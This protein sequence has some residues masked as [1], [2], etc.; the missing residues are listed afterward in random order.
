MRNVFNVKLKD[1]L[2]SNQS[3]HPT[4]SQKF[5][6]KL[7]VC[8]RASIS[9]KLTREH[10]ELLEIKIRMWLYGLPQRV[11]IKPFTDSRPYV[12]V[13]HTYSMYSIKFVHPLLVVISFHLNHVP[14]RT[15]KSKKQPLQPTL[16]II[17]T[18]RWH[19]QWLQN[20]EKCSCILKPGKTVMSLCYMYFLWLLPLSIP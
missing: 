12:Y 17:L 19:C 8:L 11:T 14:D 15:S 10:S 18:T 13:W 2:I 20:K 3:S 1:W 9:W 5:H 4:T 6:T 7:S 16:L